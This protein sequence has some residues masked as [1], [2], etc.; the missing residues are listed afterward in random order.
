[1]WPSQAN[2]LQVSAV[3]YS[4]NSAYQNILIFSNPVWGTVLVLDGVIQCTTKDERV[5][6][7]S[8]VH[9]PLMC[10]PNPQRVLLV[11]GGDGGALREILKHSC[12]TEVVMCEIDAKVIELSKQYFPGL[13]SGFEHPKSTVIVGD[14]F[15]YLKDSSDEYFDVIISDISDHVGPAEQ[16]FERKY[17]EEL[18][19]VLKPDGIISSQCMC[20]WIDLAEIKGIL[21][22]SREL[23]PVVDYAIIHTPT[24]PSGTLG[25]NLCSK[26]PET[27]FKH[28]I[29]KFSEAELDSLDVHIY[30]ENYHFASFVLPRMFKKAIET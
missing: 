18:K 1:M 25:F 19:R 9:I 2:G 5:Y 27:N 11:G 10:H 20:L 6:N 4:D 8:I 12:I 28:P 23:F 3:L 29:R 30:D 7:E 17:Y 13:A 21:K 15:Q 14:G 24:Y 22:F 26:S 16:L